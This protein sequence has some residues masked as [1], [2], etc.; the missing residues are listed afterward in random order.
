MECHCNTSSCGRESG[1]SPWGL[2]DEALLTSQRPCLQTPS[3]W[4]L[5]FHICLGW[6]AQISGLQKKRYW[7]VHTNLD[8]AGKTKVGSRETWQSHVHP[9]KTTCSGCHLGVVAI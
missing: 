8:G 1:G 5:G 9:T 7:T 3:Q 4:G 2:F 6:G